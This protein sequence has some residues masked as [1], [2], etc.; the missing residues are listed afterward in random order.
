MNSRGILQGENTDILLESGSF[1]T[2]ELSF[3][4]PGI[5]YLKASYFRMFCYFLIL[6]V[7]INNKSF[8]FNTGTRGN[9]TYSNHK[10]R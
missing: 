7:S 10:C 4:Q 9:I 3:T 5:Y 1:N 8:Y 6:N 2:T